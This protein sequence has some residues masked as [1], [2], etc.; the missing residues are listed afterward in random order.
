V[1]GVNLL[2]VIWDILHGSHVDVDVFCNLVC[3]RLHCLKE[4]SHA[5]SLLEDLVVECRTGN[6][7]QYN[8]T[9]VE[10][11]RARYHALSLKIRSAQ[12]AYPCTLWLYVSLYIPYMGK[13]SQPTIFG[14]FTSG[15]P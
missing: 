1:T 7:S 5:L 11:M 14:D 10:L 6:R 4:L 13:F 12:H 3:H 9:A 8:R 15:L 2:F